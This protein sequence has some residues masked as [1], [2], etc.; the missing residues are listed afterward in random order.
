[1]RDSAR[2]W[3]IVKT[4]IFT[5][6]LVMLVCVCILYMLSYQ[7][8]SSYGFTK[9]TMNRLSG[10]SVK[11]KYLNYFDASC[12][13]PDFIGFSD[14]HDSIGFSYGIGAVEAVYSDVLRFYDKL[15]GSEGEMTVLTPEEGEAAFSESMR[16]R[17]IYISYFCDLPKSVILGTAD[18]DKIFSGISGEYIKEIFIVPEK[19]LYEGITVGKGGVPVYTS[20]YSF[21]AVARDSEGNYYRYT[22]K[23]IPEAVGDVSFNTNYYLSYNTSGSAMRYEFAA[24]VEKDAFLEKFGFAD[25][26]TDTTVIYADRFS[27]R[28][29]S[30]E[31]EAPSD[32]TIRSILEAFFINPEKASFYSDENGVKIYFDE[33]RSVRITPEGRIQYTALGASG[34]PF[35]E[36]FGYHPDGD[37]YDTFD[38]IGAALVVTDTLEPIRDCLSVT[39]LSLFLSDIEYDGSTIRLDFGFRY[40]GIPLLLGGKADVVSFE[41]RDGMIKSISFEM[42]NAAVSDGTAQTPDFLWAV[43]SYIM[44]AS[45]KS[46]LV[47]S[48]LFSE[49]KSE[50]G[51][52][53]AA[54]S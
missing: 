14:G 54:L 36:V 48:Y 39:G 28:V 6:L 50:S 41:M 32:D 52:E 45:D 22:T 46:S 4:V 29:L 53:I 18:P 26:V 34:I 11:Y 43:R 42:W 9:D 31:R 38:Y 20:I 17:Y 15:F 24:A 35:E 7:G 1:M 40:G 2:I 8:T 3:E 12:T 49:D 27:S 30:L 5:V 51:I 16:G 19:Y 21:Y 44:D 47:F 13:L 23:Y 37:E 25:K 10:E 33:G